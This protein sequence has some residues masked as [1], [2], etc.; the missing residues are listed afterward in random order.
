[1]TPYDYMLALDPGDIHVGWAVRCQGMVAAGEWG[2]TESLREVEA[3]LQMCKDEGFLALVIL[4]TFSLYST[5]A[6]AQIGSRM[7]TSQLIGAIKL[8]CHKY[9][10][11]WLEQGASIKKPTRA[12]LRARGIKHR[13]STIHGRDAELH[14]WYRY[15]RIKEGAA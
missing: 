7:K 3:R 1:M 2:V 4:E 8:L 13:A 9:D 12:Q 6:I 11:P 10:T 14:L 5:H 15:L